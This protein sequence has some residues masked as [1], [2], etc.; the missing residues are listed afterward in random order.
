MKKSY[1]ILTDSI[2]LQDETGVIVENASKGDLVD[3]N[4]AQAS[5]FS[6]FVE[7]NDQWQ[8]IAAKSIVSEAVT[9]DTAGA[10]VTI[11]FDIYSVSGVYLASDT[12]KTGT[13]YFTGGKFS[14]KVITL[15]TAAS[16]ASTN[17]IVD[18]Q[19]DGRTVTT[20]ASDSISKVIELDTADIGNKIVSLVVAV[21]SG[22]MPQSAQFT[23]EAFDSSTASLTSRGYRF[24]A[25]ETGSN[26]LYFSASEFIEA[27]YIKVSGTLPQAVGSSYGL[28][29]KASIVDVTDL[30]AGIYFKS[31]IISSA[32]N[33]I[34]LQLVDSSGNDLDNAGIINMYLS[35]D[36][37]G[38][39]PAANTVLN[40]IAAG[41]DGA[42]LEQ[43][44][45]VNFIIISEEDGDMDLALTP[46]SA[47]VTTRSELTF[48]GTPN[49]G[50]TIEFG[51]E[52]YEWQ[53]AAGTVTAGSIFLDV[54][55]A[56][57]GAT[58]AATEFKS[59]FDANTS[60]FVES[61]RASGV[62]VII[63]T[64]FFVD[65]NALKTTDATDTASAAGWVGTS[66]GV[67][68]GTSGVTGV[69]VGDKYY[70]V[71]VLPDGRK[72][73]SDMLPYVR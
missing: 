36:S 64:K 73:V 69:D 48:T 52:I 1:R 2:T 13:N 58:A 61:S 30:P 27:K 50:D 37:R 9:S 68:S 6:E 28:T 3:L 39:D 62:V 59:K 5:D 70:L 63:A 12:G 60:Y 22:S 29:V 57:G 15:G 41:T 42:I 26:T 18:Y 34:S 55:N 31:S 47:G 33:T 35:S 49:A 72:V 44:D 23:V 38:L 51:A 53:T 19:G 11:D 71:A 43:I 56:A 14:G 32:V 66:F 10:T 24:T 7:L 45:D 40:G 65:Y 20:T 17:M 21:E 67:A 8:Q 46:T 54:A 4:A 25:A 16:A